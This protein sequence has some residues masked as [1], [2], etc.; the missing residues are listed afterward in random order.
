MASTFL[1]LHK[2]FSIQPRR[3]YLLPRGNLFAAYIPPVAGCAGNHCGVSFGCPKSQQLAVKSESTS[4][5][6]ILVLDQ[7]LCFLLSHWE[8][9]TTCGMYREC[10]VLF[11]GAW[12]NPSFGRLKI[13]NFSIPAFAWHLGMVLELPNFWVPSLHESYT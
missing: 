13:P 8:L 7:N 1:S 10:D 2:F 3:G 6:E 11:C 5:K 4:S 12:L 9:S